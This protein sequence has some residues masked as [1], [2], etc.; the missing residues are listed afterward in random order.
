MGK[1][2]SGL[3]ASGVGEIARCSKWQDRLR[4]R[5]GDGEATPVSVMNGSAESS[6]AGR[7]VFSGLA[8]GVSRKDIYLLLSSSISDCSSAWGEL[9]VSG[10]RDVLL[11]NRLLRRLL[12]LP[13]DCGLVVVDA[14]FVGVGG[15]SSLLEWL[16]RQ[17]V[18]ELLMS[19]PSMLRK[20][21]RRVSC[22]AP[23]LDPKML[24]PLPKDSGDAL[25]ARPLN[26]VLGL[27]NSCTGCAT[28]PSAEGG[29]GL[30]AMWKCAAFFDGVSGM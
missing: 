7:S 16:S 19:S 20:L 17:W 2:L 28:F 9:N 27:P 22:G 30:V 6:N 18:G 25:D 1:D 23:T 12:L 10:P 5:E 21:P 11:P 15:R 29:A 8:L 24:T 26:G 13:F 4:P 14:D 3:F